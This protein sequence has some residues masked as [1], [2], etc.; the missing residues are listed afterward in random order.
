L[1]ENLLLAFIGAGATILAAIIGAYAAIRKDRAETPAG[2]SPPPVTF[3]RYRREFALVGVGLVLAVLV[4]VIGFA[5]GQSSNERRKE[6]ERQAEIGRQIKSYSSIV[7]EGLDKKLYVLPSVVMLVTLERSA[8]GRSIV[9]DRHII[10]QLHALA[11]ISSDPSKNGDAF[12]EEYHSSYDVDRV[13]GADREVDQ[14]PK[15][16]YKQWSVLFDVA[17]GERHPVI[18]GTH[19]IMPIK[20]SAPHK[21]HMF[22]RLGA[23]EDAF[24]YPNYEGDVIEDLVI[25]V[26]SGSLKLSLPG[27]GN[28]DAVLQY[29]DKSTQSVPAALFVSEYVGH[30]HESAVARF[31]NLKKGEIAGL[32]VG[33]GSSASAN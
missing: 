19:V 26:Q 7:S 9:S 25:I 2:D 5:V 29:A 18:T 24:C 13:P 4:L 17:K 16:K 28:N 20:L 30:A 33:W 10:Y 6:L 11:D 27:S 12:V 21:E 3:R 32:R 22:E 14:E 31:K 1:S 8:D 15:P 23:T